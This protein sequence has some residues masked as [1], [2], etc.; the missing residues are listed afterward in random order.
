MGKYMSAIDLIESYIFYLKTECGLSVTLHPMKRESLISFSRLMQFNIHDNSYCSYIKSA[1]GDPRRCRAHQREIVADCP[2]EG[3]CHICYAGVLGYVYPIFNG[4]ENIGFI[5][6]SGYSCP[7]GTPA[8]KTSAEAF[9]FSYETL[10]KIYSS[11]PKKIPDKASVDTLILP[12][13]RM[14]E[15]AYLKEEKTTREESLV[16]RITRY[17]RQHYYMNLT[18]EEL[19]ARYHCSRSHFSHT[20][21]KET[22]KSFREYLTDLRLTQAKHLLRYSTI[23]VSEIA[24]SVGFSDPN[25]FSNVFRQIEGISPIEYRKRNK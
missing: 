8:V 19:C 18:T 3:A 21:K 13:C 24:F 17:I 5:S 15:L 4:Q 14:L 6:V 9:G 7:E 25:Y 12:L 1:Q 2:E 20:F 11:L 23:H 10:K 22:G 16:T